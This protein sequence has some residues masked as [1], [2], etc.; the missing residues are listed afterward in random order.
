[1]T[2]HGGDPKIGHV[3]TAGVAGEK[4]RSTTMNATTRARIH[5]LLVASALAGSILLMTVGQC[6]AGGRFP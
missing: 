3:A 5:R 2:R 6:L 4:R 1:M